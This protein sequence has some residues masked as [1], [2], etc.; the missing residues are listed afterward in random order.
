VAKVKLLVDTDVLIDFLNT[1]FLSSLFENQ[2]FEIYY[3][4]VTKKELLS[5]RGL[6]ESERKAIALMLVVEPLPSAL[7]ER[8]DPTRAVPT[9]SLKWRRSLRG[10]R[11]EDR[12]SDSVATVTVMLPRN[13]S[14]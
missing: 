4:V 5:K 14:E 10:L 11:F 7:L 2:G 13:P 8:D 6:R 9:L 12:S 3:S 1:G